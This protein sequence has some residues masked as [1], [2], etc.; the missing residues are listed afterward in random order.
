MLGQEK[1]L[2]EDSLEIIDE[3]ACGGEPAT[4]GEVSAGTSVE[5]PWT[6]VEQVAHWAGVKVHGLAV[7]AGMQR[8]QSLY[9]IKQGRRGVSRGMAEAIC[10][11]LPDLDKLWLLTGEGSMF[12]TP[13][14]Q[15]G[16]PCFNADLEKLLPDLAKY[17]SDTYG[18]LPMARS[19]DLAVTVRSD[20]L[21]PDVPAG[22]TAFLRR[23]SIGDL[24]DGQCYVVV[25]DRK[26]LL[27]RARRVLEA[28]GHDPGPAFVDCRAEGSAA[29]LRL[30]D[31]RAVYRVLG[32]YMPIEMK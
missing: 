3:E 23:E 7:D 13:S 11:N 31:V 18:R 4:A 28:D 12:R 29:P 27:C 21:Q 17:T 5:D 16:F 25:H 8:G 1:I 15:T 2:N 32:Y 24:I 30:A 14:A 19:C 20:F 6:R 10:A 22:A 9:Q 26:V